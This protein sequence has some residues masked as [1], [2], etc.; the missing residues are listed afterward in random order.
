MSRL[1]HSFSVEHAELYGIECAIIIHHFQF[2][3]EQNQKLGK[4][5]HDERTWCY[6]T[7]KEISAVYPYWNRD[8]VQAILKKLVD[9][10]VLI[11]GNYNNSQFD[12]T[13]WYAFKDEKMFTIVRNCTIESAESLTP[14]RKTAQS[15]KD[16]DTKEKDT[17]EDNIVAP[18]GALSADADDLTSFFIQKL[19]ERKAD[20]KI[21]DKKKWAQEIDRMIRIDKRDPKKIRAMID[22]IHRDSFWS[23]TILSTKK[24]REQYDQIELQA[25]RKYDTNSEKKNKEYAIRFKFKYP[26]SYKN[27]TFSG[28]YVINSG[29]GK[30]VALKMPYESFKKAFVEMFGIRFEDLNENDKK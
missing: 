30:E 21:P 24:L 26:E 10:G 29:T 15:Y 20:I 27:L 13:Q 19:K 2:W 11:K 25:K 22:W 18:S 16:I 5:F 1:N 6:Q 28:S 12:K 7:Q 23:T 9:E 3:I 14:L 4:N 17:K 8:K